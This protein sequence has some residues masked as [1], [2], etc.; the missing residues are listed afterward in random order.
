MRRSRLLYDIR[1]L[2]EKDQLHFLNVTVDELGVP[3]DRFPGLREANVRIRLLKVP[4]EISADFEVDFTAAIPCVRC[5][6]DF[7]VK[8]KEK[9]H[10]DYVAGRDPNEKSESVNLDPCEI[11][12]V[13]FRGSEIDLSVGV[14]ETIILALPIAPVCKTDCAGLCPV[15]GRNLNEGACLCRPV[16]T[17]LFNSKTEPPRRRITRTPKKK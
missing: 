16:K 6:N 17:D 11:E 9:Y 15:C 1:K 2:E 14:R 13:Y 5:L 7:E 10:L 4:D 3:A 8:L 12:R